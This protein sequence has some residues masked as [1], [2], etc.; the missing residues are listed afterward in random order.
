[1]D[2][3]E[4]KASPEATAALHRFLVE[5]RQSPEPFPCYRNPLGMNRTPRGPKTWMSMLTPMLFRAIRTGE[6]V[7]IL[8]IDPKTK[9]TVVVNPSGSIDWGEREEYEVPKG[10]SGGSLRAWD[11]ASVLYDG[12]FEGIHMTLEEDGPDE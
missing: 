8:M 7:S 12:D 2:I 10:A 11:L 5:V 6:D 9:R 3:L 1:M 4:K